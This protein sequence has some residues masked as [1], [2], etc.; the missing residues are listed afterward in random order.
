MVDCPSTSL[1]TTGL[2]ATEERLSVTV[3]WRKSRRRVGGEVLKGVWTANRG[4]READEPGAGYADLPPSVWSSRRGQGHVAFGS[5]SL[6]RASSIV[7]VFQ[8]ILAEACRDR[9][10]ARPSSSSIRPQEGPP[11]VW[12][13]KTWYTS[14]FRTRAFSA[15]DDRLA[16]R[17]ELSR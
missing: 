6:R 2:A 17:S 10:S 5:L 7:A 1:T 13:A 14:W 12:I 8:H 16:K 11:P 15:L 9:S 4:G 3:S